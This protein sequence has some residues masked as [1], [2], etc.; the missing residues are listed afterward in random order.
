VDQC[1]AGPVL[2]LSLNGS[3]SS[4]VWDAAASVWK[5]Q[6][7][8]GAVVT[9]VTGSGNGS[10]TYN[11]DYWT[12]TQRDGT[13]YQFGRNQLP[14]WVSGNTTTN[15]VDSAPVY[16]AHAGE[17][18]YN[19][20]FS[21]SV[22]TMAYRWNLD[23]VTDVHG[24]AMAYYYTQDTNYYASYLGATK[25]SYIR[26]S[27]LDH[28]DYGF[29]D[30]H[31]YGT[32]ANRVVFTPGGRCVSG[33]CT[34]LNASTKANWPDVPYDLICS[35]TATCTSQ[36][37]AFFST[38]RLA[39]I[40]TQQYDTGT[41]AY[42]P[43]DSYAFTHTMPP[44]GSGL[45]PTL[46]LSQLVRTGA[47]LTGGGSTTPIAMPPVTFGTISLANRTDTTNLPAYYR[48]RI[49]SITTETGS[50]ITPTYALVNPCTTPVTI[51]PAANTSSCYPVSW[52]P[53]G[54]SQPIKDWFNKYVVTKVTQ[55]DRTGGAPA[56]STSYVYSGGAAWHYDDN[57]V[58]KAKYRTYGQFR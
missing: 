53:D 21:L 47:D 35:S 41:S 20:T 43:I 15:S 11:T 58:V 3:S 9:R 22:C 48:H 29:T 16:A 51:N 24:S 17:P 38:V 44:A 8:N 54:Y 46:W 45:A 18:C 13:V 55:T 39:S 10:G 42:V 27:R 56:A 7:D 40:T 52:T 26:A 31:A 30:T 12:V 49:G 4:L 19:A 6:N 33:T 37:P 5:P 23:Y 34:P 25:R 14:G 32:V 2:T 57:E 1:Y 28:I 50:V 36:S